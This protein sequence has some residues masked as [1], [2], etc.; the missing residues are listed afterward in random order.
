MGFLSTTD[1]NPDIAIQFPGPVTSFDPFIGADYD[2]L[3][4]QFPCFTL[5]LNDQGTLVGYG[6][7][8]N[9]ARELVWAPAAEP[10]SLDYLWPP[11]AVQAVGVIAVPP[12][13]PPSLPRATITPE[14]LSLLLAATGL[15]LIVLF[16]TVRTH[17]RI[18]FDAKSPDS[19]FKRA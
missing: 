17:V 15:I 13:P 9:P 8:T 12:R 10:F 14:P 7:P 11:L 6:S 2:R 16:R 19:D 3:Q 1:P 5:A 18:G 4:I